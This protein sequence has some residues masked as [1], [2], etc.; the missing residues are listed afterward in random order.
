MTCL[1]GLQGKHT[2][3]NVVY[4]LEYILY[5]GGYI[6]ETRRPV[7]ERLMEHWRAAFRRDGQNSWGAHCGTEHRDTVPFR[8]EIVRRARGHVK[9]KLIKAIKKAEACSPTF[10]HRRGWRLLPTIRNWTTVPH[11]SMK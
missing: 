2:V 4:R 8:A 9:H 3:K 1:A 5:S 6:V 11:A 10:E 7:R